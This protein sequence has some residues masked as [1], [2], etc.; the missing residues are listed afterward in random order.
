MA[1]TDTKIDPELAEAA[2][3]VLPPIFRRCAR[4]YPHG[5]SAK[6]DVRVP[7]IIGDH[8]YATDGRILVRCPATPAIR[9]AA[10]AARAGRLPFVSAAEMFERYRDQSGEGVAVPS[11]DGMAECFACEGRGGVV[12]PCCRLLVEVC[13]FCDGSGVEYHA[14]RIAVTGPDDA[15][16][17][18]QYVRILSDAGATLYPPPPS[19]HHD[20]P[21][22][23]VAPGGVEG[24]VMPLKREGAAS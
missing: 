4:R 17:S 14:Q 19:P 24:L 21:F 11:L 6:H 15:C 16:L 22:R 20:L 2:F 8:V 10:E 18:P 5:E 9:A 3:L 23:F 13:D 1:E 7:A 12:C